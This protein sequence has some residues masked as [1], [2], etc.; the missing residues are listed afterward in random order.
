LFA[1]KCTNNLQVGP[2]NVPL[3]DLCVDFCW[4]NRKCLQLYRRL[5]NLS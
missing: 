5:W 1:H 2:I 4:V 3:V